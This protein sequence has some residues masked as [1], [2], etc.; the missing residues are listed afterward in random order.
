MVRRNSAMQ[1]RMRRHVR[2]TGGACHICGQPIDYTIPY[3]Q[4]GTRIPNP[5][6][7]VADHVI[8]IDGGGNHDTSNAKPAHWKCNSIKRART[9][10][11]IIKRSPTLNR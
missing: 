3:Y 10:A 8:P 6:A 9:H 4:P 11:P 7:Y 5:D 1:D 2:R